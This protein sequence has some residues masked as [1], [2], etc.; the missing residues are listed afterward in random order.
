MKKLVVALL[1]ISGVSFA[2]NVEVVKGNF[3]F[4]KDQKEIN[5]EFD[6]SNFTLLKEKKTEA[7]YVEERTADLNEKSKGN[8]NIWSK[9]WAGSRE[10]IWNPKFLELVNIVL[11]KEKKD[12]SF[13]EGLKTPYTLI[14]QT[15]WIYPGWDV[16][17]MK[18]PAKVTT[19]LKFV[20][21]ANKSNVL[22]EISSENAP[23]DQWGSNFSNES[24]IGEGYAKTG[25]SLAKLLLKKAY[26]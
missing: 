23:G 11:V 16:A 10:S 24:R 13:Q 3:D 7:Q 5:V 25:K 9:K 6:Y 17:M 12:V 14:V 19:N 1:F 15:V 22:L 26:K 18:Q 4:L 2:Q 21:T 20:E 8:G